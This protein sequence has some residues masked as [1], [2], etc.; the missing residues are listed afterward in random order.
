MYG[1]TKPY[2]IILTTL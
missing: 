1:A 2:S